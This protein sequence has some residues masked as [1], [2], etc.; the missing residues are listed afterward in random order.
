MKRR[1]FEDALQKGPYSEPSRVTIDQLNYIQERV[2][3]GDRRRP[4][5][6]VKRVI[7]IMLCFAILAIIVWI[8]LPT[9]QRST[10][11]ASM[12]PSDDQISQLI[13][14]ANPDMNPKIMYKEQ[15]NDHQMI[16]FT[17]IVQHSNQIM[18]WEAGFLHWDEGG[19]SWSVQGK[20]EVPL[21]TELEYG[22]LTTEGINE[23]FNYTF[24]PFVEKTPSLLVFGASIDPDVDSIWMTDQ[25]NQVHAAKMI[26]HAHGAYTLWFTP[27]LGLDESSYKL[28]AAD[29]ESVTEPMNFNDHEIPLYRKLDMSRFKPEEIH[30]PLNLAD[31]QTEGNPVI[32]LLNTTATETSQGISIRAAYQLRDG[33]SEF[34]IS[35]SSGDQGNPE[36]VLEDLK[37]RYP[38]ETLTETIINGHKALIEQTEIRGQIFIVTENNFYSV[39]STY[40]VDIEILLTAAKQIKVH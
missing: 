6:H 18:I 14:N 23:V 36:Q 10:Q 24:V 16:I 17:T 33:K 34:W 5:I 13:H 19:M 30:I 27:L 21:L 7:P 39:A 11:M 25:S 28:H 15:L 31:N 37:S 35:Q 38:A 32:K 4:Y 8:G 40:S 1:N 22:N 3:R 9:G 20:V 29:A 26:R 2:L 12:P